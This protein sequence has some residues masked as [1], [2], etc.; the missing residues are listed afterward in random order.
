MSEA[1][2]RFPNDTEHSAYIG[3]TG[4]GKTLA[5]LF[6]LSLQNWE[7]KPWLMMDIK[8]DEHIQKIGKMDGVTTLKWGQPIGKN[9]LH[10]IR[11]RPDQL[12]EIEDLLWYVHSRNNV[13]IYVDEGHPLKN[14]DAL[15]ALL[16]QGRSK[17]IPCR[18]CTQRP[19]WISRFVFTESSFY[20]VF[21]LTDR[22]DRKTVQEFLPIER[23]NLETPLQP[24]HSI[25]YDVK[26][27]RASSFLP[28]PPADA[29]LQSFRDRLQPRR[30]A[31]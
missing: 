24:Y 4:S 31:I 13:G 2:V 7:R 30:I 28:V 23:A 29:I 11:P 17:H 1:G 27:D 14:S 8:G 9:G 5:G 6:N 16:T 10:I 12:D 19:S 3:R 25:W 20:Q 22:R 21:S 26:A 15:N 18:I